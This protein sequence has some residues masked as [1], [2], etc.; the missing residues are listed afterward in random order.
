VAQVAGV[1]TTRDIAIFQ[2][3]GYRGLYAGETARDVAARRGL[4]KGQHILD[5]MG[6]TS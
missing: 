1:V 2:D 5:W 3:F 4:A 6:A